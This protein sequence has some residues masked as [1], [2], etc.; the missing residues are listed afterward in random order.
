ML[1]QR[2]TLLRPYISIELKSMK[3]HNLY[4]LIILL[5][6]SSGCY[7]NFDDTS[8]TI[9]VDEPEI[10]VDAYLVG[11]VRMIDGEREKE[12]VVRVN[13]V[14]QAHDNG[15]I[16][17]ELDRV[18][19]ISQS[20]YIETTEGR[21]AF[22]NLPLIR[23]DINYTEIY[24]FPQL[25]ETLISDNNES[26]IDINEEVQVALS[27][28]QFDIKDNDD[29]F[30][31]Y[32]DLSH[33]KIKRQIGVRAYDDRGIESVIDVD[34][35]FEVKWYD[36]NGV[37][38][39]ISNADDAPE[40]IGNANAL[41]GMGLFRYSVDK[42]YWVQVLSAEGKFRLFEPGIY[43]MADYREA[44]VAQSRLLVDMKPVAY[45][46]LKLD[47]VAG[48]ISLYTRTSFHG[49]WLSLVPKSAGLDVSLESPCGELSNVSRIDIL[50]TDS[51]YSDI[52][53]DPSEHQ[54][55]GVNPVIVD[56]D[57]NITDSGIINFS[58]P[59]QQAS[60]P[61]IEG[62]S[63]LWLPSCNEDVQVNV[64]E[65]QTGD[66]GPSIT[67]NHGIDQAISLLSNC[68]DFEEGYSYIMI[69]DDRKAY[70]AFDVIQSGDRTILYSQDGSMKFAFRGMQE[71][72]YEEKDVN[73]SINDSNFGQGGYF[74]SCDNS[75]VGCGVNQCIV[76]HYAESE[77]DWIRLAFE[78][79]LWMQTIDPPIAG[80]YHVEG[81]IMAKK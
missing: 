28:G 38:V 64:S 78:G 59:G 10:L 63:N 7:D 49:N 77:G 72:L 6:I 48:G 40:V 55:I 8:T 11:D 1:L 54:L 3:N 65:I 80:N 52:D 9:I 36:G 76:T 73:I 14:E 5:S 2:F 74:I 42:E 57:G 70:N 19:E 20:V 32:R 26:T 51:E 46:T 37:D 15:L 13:G 81:V 39:L 41:G 62:N 43:A 45:Q 21:D 67:W 18:N 44:V 29:L 31:S 16:N 60:Y 34:Q 47:D 66:M 71:G 50:S 33:S 22:V 24:L 79:D 25:T 53:G 69:R 58:S 17:L 75:A 35:A 61:I 4:F 56:C 12:F 23:N 27:K 30:M 68:A